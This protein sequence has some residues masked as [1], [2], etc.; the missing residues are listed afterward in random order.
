MRENGINYTK[1][2]LYN[3]ATSQVT[4]TTIHVNPSSPMHAIMLEMHTRFENDKF[5]LVN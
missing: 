5:K 1:L 4:L 2:K 3:A